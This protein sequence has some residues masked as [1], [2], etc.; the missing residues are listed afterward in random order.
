MERKYSVGSSASFSKTIT[1]HDVYAF[2]GIVGDFNSIHI[3]KVAAEKSIFGKRVVPGA[4]ISSLIS[5]VLGTKLP[6]EGTIYLSQ[7]SQFVKPVYFGD[8]ITA[9]VTINAFEKKNRATLNTDC[10][11]Q[12]GEL[13]LRGEATV[14]LPEI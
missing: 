4:L 3:N 9:T 2:A 12:T 6:G 1:E 7:E 10:F 14:I 13:V 5:T 11:N 8:T